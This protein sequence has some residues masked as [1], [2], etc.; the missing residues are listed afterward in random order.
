MST[1][2]QAVTP[3]GVVASSEAD[4]VTIPTTDGEITV[5]RNHIP[6]VSVLRPG[7]ITVIKEGSEDQHFSVSGGFAQIQADSVQILADTAERAEHIDSDRAE[8][9]RKRAEEAMS[10]TLADE[11]MA[12]VSAS[13]Q[14]NLA[15]L[16]ASEIIKSRGRNRR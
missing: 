15:R 4:S 7:V 14:R 8:T 12:E 3:E 6:L 10:G 1:R 9:A 13:L 16:R 5:L 11:E 2:F